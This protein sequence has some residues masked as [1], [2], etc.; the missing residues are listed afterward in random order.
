MQAD[1]VIDALEQL[2][3]QAPPEIEAPNEA[4]YGIYGAGELG[5]LC[6]D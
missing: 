5:Q 4:A 6:L 3:S 2:I 1:R